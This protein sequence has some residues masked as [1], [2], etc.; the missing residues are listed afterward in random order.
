[1][2]YLHHATHGHFYTTKYW[3]LITNVAEHI[4]IAGLSTGLVAGQHFQWDL[5]TFVMRSNKAPCQH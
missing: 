1:M 5:K 4:A 2:N 3:I